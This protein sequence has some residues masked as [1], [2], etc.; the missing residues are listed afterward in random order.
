MK[1][2]VLAA[3]LGT[4]M[5]PLSR[6]RPKAALP[7]L[8]V[9]LVLH[10]VR[11]LAEQGIEAAVVN[12]HRH[13]EQIAEALRAAPIPVSI[14]HEPE[15]LGSGG[16]LCAA[17]RSLAGPEPVVV[18]NADMVFEL[19]LAS[20]RATHAER[21]ALATLVLRDEPRKH[22][23]GSI[24]YAQGGWVSRVTNRARR[25][26]DLGS[27]LFAGIHLIEPQL[28][29]RMPQARSFDIMAELYA[30]MVER[31]ELLAVSLQ[32]AETAWWPV[33]TPR[34]LLEANLALLQR[35]TSGV[36][37]PPAIVASDA[38][39]GG[40]LVAPVFVGSR[41][42]IEAG[43]RAGPCSVIGA[44]A[45]LPRGSEAAESL[46]LP[47]ADPPTGK[48]QHAIGYDREVWRGA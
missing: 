29:E 31:G 19:D 7:V 33:G 47:G 20:L 10:A 24:G 15:L 39:V 3:G 21:G 45:T 9:P 11:T 23:F 5:D 41:A 4:R 27:G 32:P 14:S 38:N 25:C 37:A 40:D 46:L 1:A 13:P 43:S 36:D 35:A 8:D 12:T 2:M 30:P 44:G 34:E 42:R 22:E 48:L 6:D 18:V 26:S 28:F 16:G 17:R